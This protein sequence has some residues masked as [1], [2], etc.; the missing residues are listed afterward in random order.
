NKFSAL[1]IGNPLL[2]VTIAKEGA[3][4]APV[5]QKA[6][7][8]SGSLPLDEKTAQAYA[9]RSAELLGKLAISRGQV[10]NLLDAQPT[11]LGALDDPRPEIAKAAAYVLG[12][13]DSREPQP[14]LLTKASD[15]KAADELKVAALKGGATSA[16]FF[17][18]RL[19]G[20]QVE[21]LKKLTETAQN[22]DVKTAASE[23]LG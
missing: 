11:L 5:L 7:E 20:E 21:S 12:L 2:T 22:A 1:S 9:L 17:G 15:E 16:R 14:A 18:S 13:L 4:L 6:R 23:W 8:R 19:S 3:A 10:L